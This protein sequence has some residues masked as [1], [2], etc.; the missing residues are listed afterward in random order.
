MSIILRGIYTRRLN[1]ARP[2]FP[3]DLIAID[4]TPVRV[5][6]ALF[7]TLDACAIGERLAVEV[8]ETYKATAIR[9]AAM[10]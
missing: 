5:P 4:G 3:Y 6:S 10:A 2:D 8:T 1:T 7:A 9:K